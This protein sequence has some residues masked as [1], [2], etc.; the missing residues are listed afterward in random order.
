MIPCKDRQAPSR[1][2]SMP[3]T[4]QA[5]R[6]AARLLARQGLRGAG[7]SRFSAAAPAAAV[8]AA[9]A[10]RR[11]VSSTQRDVPRAANTASPAA[12]SK[13]SMAMASADIC[14]Y[15]F[16]PF[17]KVIPEACVALR[18]LR[19]ARAAERG[20]RE[21]AQQVGEDLQGEHRGRT[22]HMRTRAP[23]ATGIA[24]ASGC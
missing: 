20:S 16:A 19:C 14:E 9:G 15:E 7:A 3:S 23:C 2:S 17:T 4:R 13:S 8:A 18:S 11:A 5:A 22:A 12:R 21:P 10:A 1:V 6:L 24:A